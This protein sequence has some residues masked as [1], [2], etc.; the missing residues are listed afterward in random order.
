MNRRKFFRYLSRGALAGAT[1]LAFPSIPAS[2][3]FNPS[4]FFTVTALGKIFKGTHDGRLFESQDGGKSW[5][6]LANFGSHCSIVSIVERQSALYAVIGV[7][8]FTFNLKS[9][10]G[11]EWQTI[12]FIPAA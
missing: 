9:N 1:L 3:M 6:P 2:T 5:L 8:Q 10:N 7:Q 12:P 11:R 4:S